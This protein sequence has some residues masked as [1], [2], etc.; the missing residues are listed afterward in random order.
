MITTIVLILG[1]NAQSRRML[2]RQAKSEAE[3]SH[4]DTFS[5][6]IRWQEVPRLAEMGEGGCFSEADG[7]ARPS[8]LHGNSRMELY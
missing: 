4:P 6:H 8:E 7:I 3:Q 5:R 2:N 1:R